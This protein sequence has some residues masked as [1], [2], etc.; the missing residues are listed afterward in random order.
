VLE[1]QGNRIGGQETA[2]RRGM[3]MGLTMAEVAILIIFVLMLL[4]LFGEVRRWRQAR[5]MAGRVSVPEDRLRDL[6][7][8]EAMLA[9]LKSDL[10]A[11]P[12]TPPEDIQTLVRMI[13]H[14]ASTPD[15][16]AQLAQARD[17]LDDIRRARDGIAKIAGEEDDLAGIASRVEQQGFLIA[18]QEGQLRHYEQKLARAGQGKGER[19]CWVQPDGTIDYLYDVVLTSVGIRMR[20]CSNPNRASER[21]QLPTPAVDPGEVLSEATF[22]AR[23]RGLYAYSQ[24]A[25]C[26]FF[27][28][29][30]DATAADEKPLYKSLLR[31]VEGHFYKRLADGQAPF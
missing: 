12:D 22:L 24:Q 25:S 30:Y 15:L 13:Q 31:T 6:E 29:V 27:V 9:T 26:R 4:L 8:T 16:Q 28:V 21:A 7:Q 17:A 20:E 23:T 14:I 10:Q 18:N 11:K 5:S 19:P 3:V 1:G 2:Y